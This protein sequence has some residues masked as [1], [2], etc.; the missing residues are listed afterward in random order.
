[1]GDGMSSGWTAKGHKDNG[2]EGFP[3]KATHKKN[4][5]EN[6]AGSQGD[7]FG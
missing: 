6:K 7:A 5:K 4:S 1:M 3:K 2:Q